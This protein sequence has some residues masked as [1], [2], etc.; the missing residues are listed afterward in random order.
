MAAAIPR[1]RE[2]LPVAERQQTRYA[3]AMI[4]RAMTCAARTR[5][6]LIGCLFLSTSQALAGVPQRIVSLNKCADQLLVTLVDPARIASVSP[7]AA[8]EF[9]FLAER[10]K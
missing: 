9:S 1:G 6:L 2:R 3:S 4:S 7:I 5:R 10:L 8:D